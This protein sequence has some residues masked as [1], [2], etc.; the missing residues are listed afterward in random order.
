MLL[1]QKRKRMER[2]MRSVKNGYRTKSKNLNNTVSSF[3]SSIDFSLIKRQNVR[4]AHEK[5]NQFF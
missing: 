2:M 4:G 3:S 1:S 5:N